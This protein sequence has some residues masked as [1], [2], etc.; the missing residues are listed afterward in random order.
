MQDAQGNSDAMTAEVDFIIV[1]AGSAGAA[2]ANRLTESG[3]HKVLLLEAGAASHPYSRMPASFGLLISDPAANW[4]YTSAPEPATANRE[5][6]VPRGKLLGGS[7]SINGLVY[8]RGQPLDYDTWAQ[9][10]NRGWSFDDVLPIF[11]RMENYEHGA[12]DMRAQGG[13]LHV[14]ESYDQ[15]PLY[16]AIF[17]AGEAVGIRRNPDYNGAD[18]EGFVRTQTTIK[19]GIR[20]STAVAYLE[21]A[22]NRPNLR[23][24][25]GALATRLILEGK[26][27]VG[28][29]YRVANS[30]EVEVRAGRE[31]IVSCGGVAAPQLLELSGI[32][33]P[34]VLKPLGIEVKHELP[35]VGEN[36]RDH[37]NARMV[38]RLKQRGVSY[39]ER[40]SGLIPRGWQFLRYLTTRRGFM[41]MPSAPILGFLKTRQ[42]L[43]TPDIQVHVMPYVIRDAKRRLLHDWPGMTMTCYQLRPESLGTIHVRSADAREHPEIRF[44]FLSD[45]LDRQTMTDGLRL[46]RKVA[47]AAPMDPLRGEEVEPGTGATSDEDLLN[48][49]RNTANTAFHPV[50]TC[51][52]GPGPDCVVDSRLRVHGIAG[53]RIAD[54]SIMPTMVSGNTNAAAIMI[55]EKASDMIREDHPN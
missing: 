1:G 49:V 29:A 28:V 43:E 4:C 12:D 42:E 3:K 33:R 8:V 30:E 9:R 44:N 52:M 55:G 13:P 25:T 36:L 20:Q 34:D 2:L 16:E 22:R 50:G 18:Q 32:G 46:I 47:E 21:P 37:I 7:S 14:C 45:A 53:L 31:V 35:A 17:R 38:W 19:N 5:I 39:N 48:H 41:A 10:G 23:I 11:K 6:P 15:S 26:R 24:V 51:R 40:M 54:A 27:C